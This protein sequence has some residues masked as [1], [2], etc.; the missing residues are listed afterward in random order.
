MALLLQFAMY[1]SIPHHY[2][3]VART[4]IESTACEGRELYYTTRRSATPSSG[5]GTHR[6]EMEEEDG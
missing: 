4:L 3:C 6:Q 1:T 2:F 5:G